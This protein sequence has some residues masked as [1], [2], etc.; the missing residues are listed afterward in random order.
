[1]PLGSDCII[2]SERSSVISS[3]RTAWPHIITAEGR[4]W[5]VWGD[6]IWRKL[7]MKQRSNNHIHFL[8]NLVIFFVLIFTHMEK[9]G[10]SAAAL[11]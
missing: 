11:Q 7:E 8:T 1:M 10:K 2:H 3:H 6:I 4:K 9:R 5:E